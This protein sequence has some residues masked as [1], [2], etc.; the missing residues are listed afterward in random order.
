MIKLRLD[1]ADAGTPFVTET[2][3]FCRV[4]HHYI[5]GMGCIIHASRRVAGWLHLVMMYEQHPCPHKS[6][7]FGSYR[8]NL[9]IGLPGRYV[10]L[11]LL[12]GS[13]LSLRTTVRHTKTSLM[14]TGMF[15]IDLLVT[16]ILI[17]RLGLLV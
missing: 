4:C 10:Q 5:G 15:A 3:S 13:S 1:T 6:S 11:L 12:S 2:T 14:Q 16:M 17:G 7:I 8:K 9:P